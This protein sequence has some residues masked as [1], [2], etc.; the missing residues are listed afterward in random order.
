MQLD[1]LGL[2]WVVK[3]G[4]SHQGTIHPLVVQHW[5]RRKDHSFPICFLKSN[6]K[7]LIEDFDKLQ[8]L[9]YPDDVKRKAAKDY[10]LLRIKKFKEG[11]NKL[12]GQLVKGEIN[13]LNF[14]NRLNELLSQFKSDTL[15]LRHEIGRVIRLIDS[16]N[17]PG[18][19]SLVRS[20]ERT[21]NA[22]RLDILLKDINDMKEEEKKITELLDMLE[23]GLKNGRISREE[24][25]VIKEAYD[26]QLKDTRTA[27]SGLKQCMES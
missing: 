3:R 14:E 6:G 17:V 9:D 25:G 26:E 1:Y 5:E 19:L 18:I 15:K 7:I 24:R 10:P 8:S 13:S 21:E 12:T 20:V 22:Q 23:S 4:G 16:K 27:L 2:R 11:Y